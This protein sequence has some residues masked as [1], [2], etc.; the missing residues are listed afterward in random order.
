MAGISIFIVASLAC[1]LSGG[2][3]NLIAARIVQ[4][5]GAAAATALSLAMCKDLFEARHHERMM[6]HIAVIMALAPMLAPVIGGWVIHVSSWRWVFVIQAIMGTVAWVGVYRMAEPLRQ[7]EQVSASGALSAYLRLLRNRRF[8]GLLLTLSI[9]VLPFFGFI[10]G[11]TDIYMTRFGMNERQFGYFFGFNALSAM[12]GPIAFSRLSRY[13][14][15]ETLMTASFSGIMVSGCLMALLPHHSPW[16]L[17]LPMWGLSFFF[18]LSRPPGNHLML[19]QVD[20]DVGAA[21]A[22]ITFTFMTIGAFSMGA[23]SLEWSDKITVLGV[24]GGVAGAITLSVWLRYKHLF[25]PVSTRPVEPAAC[26]CK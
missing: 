24:L 4:A 15:S 6:A 13:F 8:T 10:A 19:E 18:G 11:A 25:I 1:S 2:I 17:A 26:T 20:C 23:V 14:A 16:G 12:C 22:L 5:S 9:L 7:Y 21:S 3:Y